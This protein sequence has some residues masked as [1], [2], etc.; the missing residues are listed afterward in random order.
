MCIGYFL[1]EG[2]L[3][4]RAMM[5]VACLDDASIKML[6]KNGAKIRISD[7]DKFTVL[8]FS[9]NPMQN[10][11]NLKKLVM[12]CK[13]LIGAHAYGKGITVKFEDNATYKDWV[14]VLDA[15]YG[16]T[17]MGFAPYKNKIYF[18]LPKPLPARK[19][20]SLFCGTKA[21]VWTDSIA[22]E[23][24]SFFAKMLGILEPFLRFWPSL[25]ALILMVFFAI[26]K[27]RL[28]TAHR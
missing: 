26:R 20:N 23:E 21:W 25:I 10:A 28:Q 27:R 4:K 2:Q 24:Q 19:E 18:F 5:N 22:T 14:D 11:N 17:A 8:V 9:N 12:E 7:Y 16:L 13:A 1:Y 15:G 3:S 6:N